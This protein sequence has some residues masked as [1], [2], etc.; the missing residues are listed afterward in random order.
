MQ[1]AIASNGPLTFKFARSFNGSAL[2]AIVAND[3]GGPANG[4]VDARAPKTF[5]ITTMA[6]RLFLP[7]ILHYGKFLIS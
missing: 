6:Y 3:N 5:R 7:L 4:G 2:V 1:P